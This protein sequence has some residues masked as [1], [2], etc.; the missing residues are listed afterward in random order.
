MLFRTENYL[1]FAW[2]SYDDT[3][4][5]VYYYGEDIANEDGTYNVT[6]VVLDRDGNELFTAGTTISPSSETASFSPTTPATA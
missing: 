1:N 4:S 5:L 2:Q 6:Y 3:P